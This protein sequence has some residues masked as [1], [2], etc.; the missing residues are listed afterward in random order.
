M[1][2]SMTGFGRAAVENENFQAVVEVRTLNSKFL[3]LNLRIPKNLADKE[4]EVRNLVT[5]HLGRGKV[6]LAVDIQQLKETGSQAIVNKELIKM[7]YEQ[8]KEASIYAGESHN[9]D[10]FRMATQLPHAIETVADDQMDVAAWQDIKNV[11]TEALEDCTKH[12]RD[13]GDVLGEE[14]KKYIATIRE[15]LNR[16][17]ERDPERV[18]VVRERIYNH[19]REF[20]AEDQIDQNRYEQEMI[21]YIEKLDI[22]EEKIRL[23]SHLDYF[24]EM[25]EKEGNNGKK[26][27]FIAQEIGREINTIGSKANDAEIQRTVVDMKDELEK[28]KEQILNVV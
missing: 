25:L 17:I 16:V 8:L 1:I 7:Y 14:L 3:D 20:L 4:M 24:N 28:I 21:Y 9:P 26:L 2:I 12:R 10:L 23:K 19:A 13:E 15:G 11:I 6:S 5:R 27:G 22:S 18:K